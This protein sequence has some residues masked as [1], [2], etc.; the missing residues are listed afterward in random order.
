MKKLNYLIFAGSIFISVNF[1]YAQTGP[2]GVG[3]S[4][5]NNFWIDANTLTVNNGDNLSTINDVSGNGNNFNQPSSVAQPQYQQNVVN[6][7]PAFQF[8]GSDYMHSGSI[9]AI[10]SGAISWFAVYQKASLQ[11]QGILGGNYS[12][13][14]TQWLSYCNSGDDYIINAHYSTGGITYNKYLDD[15]SFNFL[16][17]VITPTNLKTYENGGLIGTKNATYTAPTGHNYV[18]L[19]IYP[20]T[21]TGY[22]LN[23][24]IAEAF[25]FN[26]AVNDLERILIENYLGAKY[27]LSIPTDYYSF[28][29][30]HNI[31]VI[32]IGDDGTNSHTTSQGNGIVEISSPTAMTSG[33]YFLFGH[34]NVALS[35][36]VNSDLPA[37][38]STHSRYDRTWKVDETGEVGNVTL[39][40]DLSGNNGFADP[41]TYNLLVDDDGNFSNATVVSGTYNSG[42]QTMTFTLDLNSGQYFTISGLYATPTAIRSV[43]SG[44]WGN[45]ANWDCGCVPTNKDTVYIENG[46]SIGVNIDA[47]AYNLFVTSTSTLK[48]TDDF[49]LSIYGDLQID[50]TASITNGEIKFLGDV[51]QTISAAGNSVSLNRVEINNS[52]QSD[53]SFTNG[54][55]ILESTLFPN[56]GNMIIGTGGSFIIN[57]TSATTSGRVDIMSSNFSITGDV[58]V[59]RFLASGNADERNLASPITNATLSMWDADIEI[60]G[61]GFPDGCA[62]DTACYYSVKQY[63]NGAYIDITDINHVLE[64]GEGYEVFVGTDLNTFAGATLNV[65]GTLR[66]YQDFTKYVPRGG[67]SINGNPYASPIL[68]SNTAHDVNIGDYFYVY[69]ASTGG[70]Q[71]YDGSN[72]TSSI[73]ELA[74]GL[75]GISQGFWLYNSNGNTAY[76]VYYKQASKTSNTATFIRNS[77]DVDNSIYLTMTESGTT[78]KCITS[79][80]FDPIA[81]DVHDSLDIRNLTTGREK[82]SSLLF[83]SSVGMLRKQYLADDNRDKTLDMSIK[84]LN[85]GYFTI[86][87]SNLENVYRYNNIT[88]IDNVTGDV[89]DLKKQSSY[90]FYSEVG[91][92][93]R[94]QLVLSNTAINNV[95]ASIFESD[96][97]GDELT[98]TQLGNSINVESEDE[99]EGVTEI[100]IV[101][102]LG[103]DVVYTE[104]INIQ[105]G[106]NMIF[107]PEELSGMYLVVI[108][109]SKGVQTKKIML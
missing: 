101:N 47:N 25:V 49:S 80:G 65:T 96:S 36:I 4:S 23:G 93:Q 63:E 27:N 17:N 59:R 5:T 105:S 44:D 54:T 14:A 40:F 32:G 11:S 73:P 8:D 2:G 39:V 86:E 31:N 3:N 76:R 1:G 56:K 92:F 109:S 107:M 58:T 87:P 72:N 60:S 64:S 95:E 78:Y 33:E 67:W 26:Y 28:E 6:S 13:S 57:S 103:Q 21:T 20:S 84:I 102:L 38:I 97:N 24:Y 88:L 22:F 75:I 90:V 9:P 10:E 61:Q 41:A 69:D 35:S 43:A 82:A 94:F 79:V 91:E 45:S 106:S 66:D 18:S 99:I 70:Y 34:T 100:S 98:I 104:S 7:L 12:S 46:F 53:V 52:T 50:G 85:E 16:G 48:M 83:N 89:I 51:N 29:A 74:N 37:S 55:Y 71:W 62:Y 15:G 30:T 68:F 42:N 108:K 81:T 77:S 19:G